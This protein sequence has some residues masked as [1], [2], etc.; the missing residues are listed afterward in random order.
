ML[1]HVENNFLAQKRGQAAID[2]KAVYAKTIRMMNSHYTQAL[3]ARQAN[4][5]R[6]VTLTAAARSARAA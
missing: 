2:H 3:Q 5:P 4:P 6:C 1:S